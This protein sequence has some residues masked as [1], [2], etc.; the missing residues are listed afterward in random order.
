MSFLTLVKTLIK[1]KPVYERDNAIQVALTSVQLENLRIRVGAFETPSEQTDLS[2]TRV[3]EILQ[4]HRSHPAFDLSKNCLT[5]AVQ[6]GVRGR[7]AKWFLMDGQHRVEAMKNVEDFPFL[8]T[9]QNT[10]TNDDIRELFRQINIDSHK[11]RPFI[12]LSKEDAKMADDLYDYL[13]QASGHLFRDGTRVRT[14]RDLV[15]TLGNAYFSKFASFE[16][17]GKDFEYKNTLFVHKVK[18]FFDFCYSDEKACCDA[19]FVAPLKEA[20]FVD[21]LLYGSSPY[22]VGKKRGSRT[23]NAALK[24]AVWIAYFPTASEG[25]C[26]CC[27]AS[28]I[29]SRNFDCGHVVSVFDGGKTILGNLRPIC[30]TCNS[31][32]GKKNMDEFMKESG[33]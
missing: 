8:V 30:G 27:K 14:I 13:K 29:G 15:D 1:V 4:A 10:P 25:K 23:I 3:A 18:P 32:M 12:L 17:L 22:Y 19:G 11:N 16:E 33:F 31:S 5:V 26:V 6:L 21:Y 7:K 2:T 24:N 9:I 20:N 28:T